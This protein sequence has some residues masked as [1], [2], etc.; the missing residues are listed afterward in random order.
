MNRDQSKGRI[1]AANGRARE[2][3][4]KVKGN[5]GLEQKGKLQ[6]DLG[7]AQAAYG[8]LQEKIKNAK[9]SP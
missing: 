2:I 1:Q 6:K 7:R 5:I 3:V 8:D 9:P 4:G